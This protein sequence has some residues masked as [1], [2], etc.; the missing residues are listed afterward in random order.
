MDISAALVL[1]YF[2]ATKH[3]LEQ[4]E[5]DCKHRAKC[6]EIWSG[7]SLFKIIT[8]PYRVLDKV[9][10]RLIRQKIFFIQF[11]WARLT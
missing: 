5:A 10:E 8:Q 6:A 7:F 1:P 2:A 3:H 4:E 11:L 9:R